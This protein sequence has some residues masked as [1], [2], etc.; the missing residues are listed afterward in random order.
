MRYIL[1]DMQSILLQ[2]DLVIRSAIGHSKFK[3][4][5]DDGSVIIGIYRGLSFE[6]NNRGLHSAYI[7]VDTATHDDSHHLELWRLRHLIPLD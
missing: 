6:P 3:F 1:S 7:K 2:A 5:L 4:E